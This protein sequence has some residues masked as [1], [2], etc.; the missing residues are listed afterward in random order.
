MSQNDSRDNFL[1]R[2][3]FDEWSPST[4]QHMA[5]KL[6]QLAAS[7]IQGGSSYNI[8][9]TKYWTYWKQIQPKVE[10]RMNA[11]DTGNTGGIF[12]VA[13][14]KKLVS[15]EWTIECGICFVSWLVIRFEFLTFLLC[16]LR[17]E[18]FD[19]FRD[20]CIDG[21]TFHPDHR[22]TSG[23]KC[24]M[25]TGQYLRVKNKKENEEVQ[26]IGIVCTCPNGNHAPITT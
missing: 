11:N 10:K 25:A 4:I 12:S 2:N 18:N 13:E 5:T 26:Q 22:D 14:L 8:T 7:N 1:H 16:A 9:W 23:K 17:T 20:I 6:L 3:L 21:I 19:R 24:P 15:W